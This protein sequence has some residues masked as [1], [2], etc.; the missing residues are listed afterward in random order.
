[1][2]FIDDINNLQAYDQK[3]GKR[4]AD[5]VAEHEQE[6][7]NFTLKW[8]FPTG[9]LSKS[10]DHAISELRLSAAFPD[11]MTVAILSSIEALPFATDNFAKREEDLPN[12]G[13]IDP[14]SPSFLRDSILQLRPNEL[15]NFAI[16]YRM[17]YAG[18]QHLTG[19]RVQLAEGVYFPITK[20]FCDVSI[21]KGARISKEENGPTLVD[22]EPLTERLK[23]VD[24]D[25]PQEVL[26]DR[27]EGDA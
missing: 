15:P 5:F 17:K 21:W 3:Q 8:Q 12:S 25:I 11:V 16:E 10:I 26:E 4:R 2:E 18:R 24:W 9:E 14:D 6:S 1:V 7:D 22:R 13:T 23:N 19:E 20:S 27:A